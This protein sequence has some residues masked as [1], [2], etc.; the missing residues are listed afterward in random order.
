MMYVS[1][2]KYNTS[3]GVQMYVTSA[4]LLFME[5]TMLTNDWSGKFPSLHGPIIVSAYREVGFAPA[6]DTLVAN[7]ISKGPSPAF[8]ELKPF[9]WRRVATLSRRPRDCS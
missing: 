5:E 9:S 1:Q 8:S 3:G 6:T 4:S 2:E 7:V